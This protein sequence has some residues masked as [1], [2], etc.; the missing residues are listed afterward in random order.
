MS[1]LDGASS[2]RS[3]EAQRGSSSGALGWQRRVSDGSIQ[4]QRTDEGTQST[5]TST[6]NHYAR[7]RV[8]V[9]M[10]GTAQDTLAGALD[11]LHREG[12]RFLGKFEVL[13]FLARREGGQG[14][15]QFMRRHRSGT[16]YA[17]K[18]FD[19]RNGA[20]QAWSTN[21]RLQVLLI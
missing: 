8:D 9:S 17:V 20:H 5:D 11:Y 19:A 4:Q 10:S 6:I 14:T 15:V 1:R 18:F 3:V 7:A 12:E 21:C 16:E 13:D 2:R